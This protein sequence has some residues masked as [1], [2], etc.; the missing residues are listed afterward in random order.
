MRRKS[1][2]LVFILIIGMSLSCNSLIHYNLNNQEKRC[3]YWKAKID[4]ALPLS[5]KGV[6]EMPSDEEAMLVIACLLDLEGR[7]EPARFGG[8]TRYDV[9]TILDMPSIEIA[10]LYY[11]SFIYTKKRDHAGMIAILGPD[12]E[13]NTPF[14][15]NKAFIAYKKWFKKVKQIG[16]NEARCQKL[17]PLQDTDL[18][19][20]R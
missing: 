9:S 5:G 4:P 6:W 16:L 11:I 19:W 18:D 1:F 3:E 8:A 20:H 2:F 12:G 10:S 17:E 15:A 14:V 7:K 13:I